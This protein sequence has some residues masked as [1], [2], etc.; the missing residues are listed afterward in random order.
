MER[1]SLGFQGAKKA[2][3]HRTAASER[4]AKG[5]ERCI[6][7]SMPILGILRVPQHI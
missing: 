7:P 5:T 2:V 3:L 6:D 1:L 4:G